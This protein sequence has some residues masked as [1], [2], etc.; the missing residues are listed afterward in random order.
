M[1]TAFP[2]RATTFCRVEDLERLCIASDGVPP[3]PHESDRVSSRFRPNAPARVGDQSALEER[4]HTTR[5]RRIR[6]DDSE[7]R[8]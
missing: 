3:R 6:L 7:G 1:A 5:S 8:G 2:D 4:L